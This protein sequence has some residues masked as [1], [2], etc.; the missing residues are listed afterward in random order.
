LWAKFGEKGDTGSK[1]DKGDTGVSTFT[2]F[3]FTRCP[4]SID[5][6]GTYLSDDIRPANVQTY[7]DQEHT[8]LVEWEEGGVTKHVEWHDTIP[9]GTGKVWMSTNII[10]DGAIDQG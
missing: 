7:T 3:I 2:S 1:G 4:N 9:I 5:L 6:S 8:H 10:N